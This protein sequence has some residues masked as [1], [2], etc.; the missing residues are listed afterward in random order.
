M[1]QAYEQETLDELL[2]FK[3]STIHKYNLYILTEDDER[4]KEV[5]VRK[6]ENIGKGERHARKQ[7]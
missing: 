7:S 4:D 6:R 5:K 2:G 1:A 3:S